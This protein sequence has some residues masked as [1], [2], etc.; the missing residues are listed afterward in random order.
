MSYSTGVQSR[1][2]APK[3]ETDIDD[4][5][6]HTLHLSIAEPKS[7]AWAPLFRDY[8]NPL[9]LTLLSAYVRLYGIS[10]NYKVLWDEA[11][12]GKFGL[13]YL[14]HEFYFDVHPP[15][16][17]MLVGLS[18][19]LAG[20]DG[21]FSFESGKLYPP[22]VNYRL[23]RQFNCVF[24]I[25]CTPMA[26]YAAVNLG[27]SQWTV[28]LILLL[29][30][31]EMLS[32][33]LSKF[34]L[35]DLM[36]LFFT[37]ASFSCLVKVHAFRHRLL[38]FKGL[39]WL[40]LTGLSVGCVC[41]VKW[42]G[43]FVTLLVG[44]YTAYDL[45]VRFYAVKSMHDAG[46]HLLHWAA[47]V[48]T[49]IVLPTAIYVYSFK[50]HF[51]L[52]SGSGPG[53]GSILTLLQ[54]SLHNNTLKN[55]PRS[56]AYGSMVTLRS[57]GLSPNLLHS[58]GSVYPSGLRQQQVTTYG[59]KDNN[60][61]FLL[62]FPLEEAAR[63]RVATFESDNVDDFRQLVKD[64]DVVRL[65]H[66]E[67]GC[68]LHSHQFP[69]FVTPSS[70]EV[71]CYGN[72]DIAD[73][74]DEWIVEIQSQYESPDAFFSEPANEVHPVSTNFR[75]R[76]RVLGCHLA[77]TGYLYPAWGFQQGEVVCKHLMF[78]K[79]KSTWWNV[80]DHANEYLPQ[81][82][83]PYVAPRP[84]FTKELILLNY[85][86]MAS[87]NALI[88]DK[89]HEDRLASEWWEWPILYDG[90]R[91]GAWSAGEHKYFLIG[92]PLV[93][94]SGTFSI[95][96]TLVLLVVTLVRW[97]RQMVDLG[98]GTH[99]WNYLLS[100][101]IFPVLGWLL[102]YVPF[103]LMGRVTYIH[104]YVPAMFFSIFATG[105]VCE[106]LVR[107]HRAWIYGAYY[108]CIFAT[109]YK[110]RELSLG[111]TRPPWTLDNVRLFGTWSL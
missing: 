101:G 30:V 90:L 109:F 14:K 108:V 2:P 52:L 29:V 59:F 58:H 16:G 55:G 79:D 43:L 15:L 50:A 91:M 99:Q 107:K 68:F 38:S 102:H 37:V 77:T 100:A 54:A 82:P 21:L 71:S 67:T 73:E 76:H 105:Y 27:Y 57:Q 3:P 72:I 88:P 89:D 23:M 26:Y 10:Y 106:E 61:E 51:Y 11:H 42:V 98:V 36:L 63:G 47:R 56:V 19:Y 46:V 5:I 17:K 13:Y 75:L 7:R 41:S 20:Y 18:G 81:P 80:E 83:R 28:W 1:G 4:I 78:A 94:L 49:L 64:G 103:I 48:L 9:L 32:L 86:M 85:G 53:D 65:M 44:M 22:E 93:T 110:F 25:L 97:R 35:L 87:N 40:A 34:I 62:E 6:R 96:A 31:F 33:T 111:T 39:F 84:K 24:G 92:H 69:G 12:F 66:R 95:G 60:N 74:K 70:L 45:L 8:I 104:H